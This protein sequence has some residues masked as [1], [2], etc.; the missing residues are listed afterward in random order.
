M[1]TAGKVAIVVAAAGGGYVVWRLWGRRWWL[2]HVPGSG[3]GAPPASG[4][5]GGGGPVD[6]T[7]PPFQASGAGY[8]PAVAPIVDSWSS[9]FGSVGAYVAPAIPFAPPPPPGAPPAPLPPAPPPVPVTIIGAT[10]DG[11]GLPTQTTLYVPPGATDAQVLSKA[12]DLA[13]IMASGLP[14]AGFIR[15]DDYTTP[16]PP[17]TLPTARRGRGHF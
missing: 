10:L 8:G 12:A 17:A 7:Y 14:P 1:G 9:S 3:L 15:D 6:V 11:A 2:S 5:S 13:A 4:A 16:D